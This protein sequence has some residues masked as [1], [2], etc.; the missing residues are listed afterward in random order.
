MRAAR[1][2]AMMVTAAALVAARQA[3]PVRA[4]EPG[5]AVPPE[6]LVIRAQPAVFRVLCY[7]D[8]EVSYPRSL[9]PD[10]ELLKREYAEA[11]QSG[12]LPPNLSQSD[13]FWAQIAA[14]GPRFLKASKED[15]GRSLENVLCSSGTA[16]AIDPTG[17]LLTN[18]HVVGPPP[19]DVVLKEPLYFAM[20]FADPIEGMVKELAR[21]FGGPPPEAIAGP[22]LVGIMKTLT[23]DDRIKIQGKFARAEIAMYFGTDYDATVAYWKAPRRPG[24]LVQPAEGVPIALGVEVVAKGE[25]YPGVDVAVLRACRKRDASGRLVPESMAERFIADRNP[26]VE[27]FPP[28]AFISLPLGDSDEVIEGSR[29]QALGF[30]GGAF[31]AGQMRPEAGYRVSCLDGQI[32][33]TRVPIKGGWDAF[34]MTA[35]INHGD[36]GGPV[37]D[38]NGR[39]IGLNVAVT[40]ISGH[41]MAVP[42]NLAKDLLHKAGIKV[43]APGAA[44]QQWEDALRMYSQ[45]RY[46][47]AKRQLE[48]VVRQR[49][50]LF[51]SAVK[52]LSLEKSFVWRPTLQDPFGKNPPQ[53]PVLNLDPYVKSMALR[54]DRKLGGGSTQG[55]TS[56]K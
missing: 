10:M 49:D 45:G 32:S 5:S 1:F 17:L 56:A 29:I 9:S 22:I 21:S 39:V 15:A 19:A 31:T 28:A 24:G 27:F 55:T 50:P 25:E 54:C 4:D 11:R 16:F 53:A 42:I 37:L 43:Q 40:W 33:R 7:G 35:D 30:P 18:A 41:T 47:E 38:K 14:G 13:F 51:S 46:Q 2:V 44:T 3:G 12:V 8:F 23:Q 26:N 34:E 36:S 48:A 52:T 6:L 20:V